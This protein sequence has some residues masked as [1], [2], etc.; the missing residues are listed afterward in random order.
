LYGK[1]FAKAFKLQVL[2]L[3]RLDVDRD[4]AGVHL[5]IHDSLYRCMEGQADDVCLQH[6][7]LRVLVE[8]RDEPAEEMEPLVVEKG[9]LPPNLVDALLD[10][11]PNLLRE[12]HGEEPRL[13][14]QFRNFLN[15][16]GFMQIV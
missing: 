8:V 5:Q 7:R 11:H 1:N 6:G 2:T 4:L 15:T 10:D 12:I 3:P 16:T 13:C 9:V 14:I